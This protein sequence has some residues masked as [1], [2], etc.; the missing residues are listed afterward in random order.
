M[1]LNRDAEAALAPLNDRGAAENEC[2]HSARNRVQSA[3][4]VQGCSD[5]DVA[6]NGSARVA[7]RARGLDSM[8]GYDERRFGV[9]DRGP[10]A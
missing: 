4:D 6:L 10:R 5:A 9:A 2:V 8:I 7:E 3:T 1:R